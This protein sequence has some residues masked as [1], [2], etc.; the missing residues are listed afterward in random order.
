VIDLAEQALGVVNIRQLLANGAHVERHS[1]IQ[2]CI[3]ILASE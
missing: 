2:R 1:A 3:I